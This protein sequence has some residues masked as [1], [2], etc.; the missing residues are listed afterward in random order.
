METRVLLAFFLSLVILIGWQFVFPSP[1]PAHSPSSSVGT[2]LP[3]AVTPT[4]QS[5]VPRPDLTQSWSPP[6]VVQREVLE[7]EYVHILFSNENGGGISEITLKQFY[8]T[9]VRKKNYT[10]FQSTHSGSLFRMFDQDVGCFSS[11]PRLHKVS[12]Q[13]LQFT[14]A[15][16][17]AAGKE[18]WAKAIY[19][20]KLPYLLALSIQFAGP[21][22]FSGKEIN[23][24]FPI[25]AG[26]R[27]GLSSYNSEQVVYSA[28]G[29]ISRMDVSGK[30]TQPL[31]LTQMP[32]E[33]ISFGDR[34]FF[35]G[36]HPISDMKPVVTAHVSSDSSS[37]GASY[38]VM[39]FLFPKE[40]T[41]TQLDLQTFVGPKDRTLLQGFGTMDQVVDFGIFRFI[42]IPIWYFLKFFY[43]YLISNFGVAII[44]L[45]I[46]VRL[47]FFPLTLKGMGSMKAMQTIQPQIS[48]LKEKYKDDKQKLNQEMVLLLRAHKINPLGG[49]LPILIQI[50]VFIALYAVLGNAVELY[51]ADFAMWID[52]LSSK[53][54]YYVLPVLLGVSFLVQQKL[55]PS[56]VDPQT[57]KIMMFMPIMFT[58]FMLNLPSGLNLYIFTSTLLGI[59]Q[60]LIMNNKTTRTSV[61]PL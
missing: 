31:T 60:Q 24:S 5:S 30:E 61:S 11:A 22:I 16:K 19:T 26:K 41:P 35:V 44:V 49:C 2:V 59:V 4:S 27:N 12:D 38:L 14:Y 47:L 45:T 46:L 7:N 39:Q 57:Q 15:C 55:T 48:K 52:D 13:T 50:P 42:A 40:N 6:S 34:Y 29:N 56:T 8:E 1:K 36:V 53:D 54:P 23:I 21:H 28:G 51:Q 9:S 58:V 25:N 18:N 10:L 43:D 3:T 37:L 17:P 33:W 20:L 32:M